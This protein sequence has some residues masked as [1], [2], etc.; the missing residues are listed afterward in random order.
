MKNWYSRYDMC[1]KYGY[2]SSEVR[3]RMESD[4]LAN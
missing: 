4:V 3:L 2:V 1:Y